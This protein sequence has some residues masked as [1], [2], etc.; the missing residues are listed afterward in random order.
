L[1]AQIQ[2][3]E[4]QAR[5]NLANAR[6]GADKG[7]EIE[8]ISRVNENEALAV[9]RKAQAIHDL[10]LANVEKLKAIKELSTMDLSQLEQLLNIAERLRGQEQQK[11][12]NLQESAKSMQ[13]P[14]T[15]T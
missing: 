2:I 13:Q 11:A 7:L 9:E 4:L 5:A 8:R 14:A 6:A 15:T 3:Q 10:E 1:Q 12:E